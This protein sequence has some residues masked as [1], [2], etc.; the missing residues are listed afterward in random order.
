MGGQIVDASLAAVAR[1]RN[2]L[3]EKAQI[4]AG[5][6]AREIWRTPMHAGR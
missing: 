4:K 5:R 3:A 1:Q 6:K 2:T